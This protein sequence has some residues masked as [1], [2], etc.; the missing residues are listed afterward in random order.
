MRRIGEVAGYTPEELLG[1]SLY[2]YVHALDSD[3][4][5]RS[6]HTREC[7]PNPPPAPQDPSG[8]ARILLGTPGFPLHPNIILGTPITSH[9]AQHHSC[10]LSTPM[11]SWVTPGHRNIPLSTPT[12]PPAPSGTLISPWGTPGHPNIRP[13][14]P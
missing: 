10:T 1:C 12:S 14:H 2:E 13:G 3:T 5:S 6:V 9:E 4:L 7:P 8:N 11:S